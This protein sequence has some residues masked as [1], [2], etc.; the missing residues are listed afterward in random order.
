MGGD[1]R[2]AIGLDGWVQRMM[3]T[4]ASPHRSVVKPSPWPVRADHVDAFLG[5]EG[6]IPDFRCACKIQLVA[7]R[8]LTFG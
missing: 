2:S 5:K 6:R 4:L 8:K 7:M 3:A 1:F